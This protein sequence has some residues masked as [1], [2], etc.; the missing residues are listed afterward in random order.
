MNNNNFFINELEKIS[1]QLR[2]IHDNVPDLK[3]V[4][5]E[6]KEQNTEITVLHSEDMDRL[7]MELINIVKT[8]LSIELKL[9]ALHAVKQANL[10][11]Q[12]NQSAIEDGDDICFIGTRVR[13]TGNS[14]SA[15]WYKNYFHNPGGT[16]PLGNG[17]N[18]QKTNV[19][20]IYIKKNNK[21]GYNMSQFKS[22]PVWAKEVIRIVEDKYRPLRTRS[23][24][25]TKVRRLIN[26]Y[27]KKLK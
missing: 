24:T 20:S 27:E 12:T 25:L 3:D 1:E 18:K 14:L 16:S 11:W 5:K 8:A 6:L 23:S 7:T 9:V 26:D 17:E 4:Q 19:Y 22:V 21:E 15:E 2:K 13:L 10:F